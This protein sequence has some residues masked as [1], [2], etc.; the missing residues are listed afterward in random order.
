MSVMFYLASPEGGRRSTNTADALTQLRTKVF[1]AEGGVRSS[2]AAIPRVAVVITDGRS[3][4]NASQ[5]IPSALALRESGVIVHSV[6]V[7]S[8]DKSSV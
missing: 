6:G 1:T 5:T 4:I 3:N 8:I 2:D 7:V